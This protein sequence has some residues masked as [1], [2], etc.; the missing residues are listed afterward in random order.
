MSALSDFRA[1]IVSRIS[2]MSGYYECPGGDS[3]QIP[4]HWAAGFIV[5]MPTWSAIGQGAT[6]RVDG[7]GSVELW[8]RADQ[9]AFEQGAWLTAWEALR[10]RL[11]S[12][13]WTGA[14]VGVIRVTAAQTRRVDDR[15][16]G[17]VGF[18]WTL[19]YARA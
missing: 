9:M 4:D 1:A 3:T 7:S 15:F 17:V 18:D 6:E 19:T 13:A 2:A 16:V 12:T 5:D 10:S 11:E 14:G 8:Y